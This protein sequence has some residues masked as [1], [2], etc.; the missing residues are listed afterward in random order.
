MSL[1]L[2]AGTSS[3]HYGALASRILYVF[4]GLALLR[5]LILLPASKGGT[6]FTPIWNAVEKYLSGLPVYDGDYSTQD[7]HYLYS[8][9]A[10]F[11]L[12]PIG[13]LPN[14]A[15][16]RW[17]MMLLG[18]ACVLV[19][20]AIVIRMIR[21]SVFHIAFPLTVA[22]TF[23]TGEPV[24]ST[25]I[26]TNING[27]LLLC[28]VVFV[29]ASI[30]LKRKAQ[31]EKL[32]SWRGQ[33][34]VALNKYSVIAG[35]ALGL[36]VGIKPQFAVLA[37]ISLATYQLAP[38]VY[39]GVFMVVTF[40]LGWLT[41]AQP[42]DYFN[43]LV[44]YLGEARSYANG[45]IQGIGAN[46]GWSETTMFV[47]TLLLIAVTL[48]AVILLL[49]MRDQDPIMWMF[50]TT[51]VLF[52]GLLMSSGLVQGY[53]SMWLIPMILTVLSRVSPMH[54]PWIWI[55][56]FF[57]FSTIDFPTHMW[58]AVDAVMQWRASIAWV[59]VPVIVLVWAGLQL[60]GTKKP[61]PTA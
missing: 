42:E 14:E 44:P 41:M 10:T 50:V 55:P 38:L 16:A 27:F 31:D 12:S 22:I 8:P 56:I 9:G 46:V 19:A 43:R 33:K 11:V 36:A 5:T 30:Q 32:L 4:A 26:L 13:I 28:M 60:R 59:L 61:E 45:S 53:Y 20:I 23:T 29:W 21:P 49:P 7:P 15:V 17:V 25:L 34:I 47:L 2:R 37:F 54:T 24:A 48:F 58:P 57:L 3:S 18:A 52:C 40:I 39:A 51:G 1:K 6:D 35:I